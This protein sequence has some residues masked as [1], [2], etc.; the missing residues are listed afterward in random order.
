MDE[1]NKHTHHGDLTMLNVSLPEWQRWRRCLASAI[2]E[3]R[4]ARLNHRTLS[5]SNLARHFKRI[6]S[7]GLLDP[8]EQACHEAEQIGV[9]YLRRRTCR[10]F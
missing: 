2:R 10:G 6:W 5:A 1:R 4:H 7:D 9:Q 3:Y 8:A